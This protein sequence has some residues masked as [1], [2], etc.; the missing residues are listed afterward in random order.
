MISAP[1]K[2]QVQMRKLVPAL[3]GVAAEGHTR[4]KVPT[5][6]PAGGKVRPRGSCTGKRSMTLKKKKK[7]RLGF[8]DN[9]ILHFSDFV[10]SLVK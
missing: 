10:P 3:R 6:F 2:A 4:Y 9:Q 5:D 1:D 8:A 7:Y